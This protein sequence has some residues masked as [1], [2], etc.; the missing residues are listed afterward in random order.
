[1]INMVPAYEEQQHKQYRELVSNHLKSHLKDLKL[2]FN[3]MKKLGLKEE[4]IK[5]KFARLFLDQRTL[6]LVTDK[7]SQS[8]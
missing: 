1:M 5:E 6:Y 7:E 4:F 2:N 3:Y 8:L